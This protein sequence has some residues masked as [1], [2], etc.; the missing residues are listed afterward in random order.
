MHAYTFVIV[1]VQFND[2][3][4][5]PLCSDESDVEL[6]GLQAMLGSHVPVYGTPRSGYT[7]HDLISMVCE[8]VPGMKVCTQKPTGVRTFTSFVVDLKRV[9]LKD[10]AADDNGVWVTSTPR[11]M[12]EIERKE[13][14]ICSLRHISKVTSEIDKHNVITLCRQYGTHQATP[15]FRRII[16]TVIDSKGV[17]MPRAIVQYFFLGDKKVPVHVQPHGNSKAKERPYYRTQP[18][19]LQAIKER[20]K[21]NPASVTYSDIF[22]A[23]GGID[24]CKSMSEEPRN[25][26]QVYNAC[27]S[28]KNESLE[29]KD[30]IYDLLALLKEHQ[31]LEDGGFLREVLIGSTPCAILASKR[32]LDNVVMFCCQPTQFS[33]FGIDATFELGD[34]YVTLTTYKNPSLR[35]CRTNNLPVFLGPAFIHMERRTQDYQSFFSSLLKFEPR[36]RDLKAYGTDGEAALTAALESCFP[37]AI[38]LRC[39]IHKRNNIE[40]HLKG[41]SSAVKKEILRDI[42]GSQDGEVFNTGLVDSDSEEAFDVGLGRIYQRWEQLAPGLH[43]WFLTHQADVFCRHMIRPIREQ[44]Q[45]GSPPEKF[46]NNPNE[47]SNS[48]VKHWTGFKK[49]S[50]PAFVQKLQKLVESQLS[51]ADKAIYG[52]GE[53]SLPAELSHFQVDGVRWHRMSTAQRKAHLR[54]IASAISANQDKTHSKKLSVSATDV[55]L[56]TISTT[57]LQNMWGK[58]ERLLATP[59]AITPAPGN[60]SAR[61]VVSDSSPRPHFVQKTTSG[62]FL[63]DDSC[64]MWRGRKVCA[65]TV[66]VAESLNCLQ[67]FIEALQKSKPECSVTKLVTTSSDRRKAG[68]KSGAPRK[69]GSDL[70]KTPVTTYRSRLDDVCSPDLGTSSGTKTTPSTSCGGYGQHSS[71][72]AKNSS[73]SGDIS[74]GYTSQTFLSGCSPQY[75]GDYPNYFPMSPWYGSDFLQPSYPYCESQGMYGYPYGTQFQSPPQMFSSPQSE[76]S[77]AAATNPFIV[78]L[79][80]NRIKKCRG[81]NRE[82]SRK[83]DGSPPDP[84]LNLVICHEERRPFCGA[85]NATRLSRPQN[86][87]YH[88]N[89]AC[90]RANN[91]TFVGREVQI[92]TDIELSGAHKKYLRE[93]FGCE[94]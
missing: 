42:F 21:T 41:S 63:C 79:L 70:Y 35:N 90:V 32:Q 67:Q 89:L 78:K 34:F 51:E 1:C 26:S 16:A 29:S 68:T 92:P 76:S 12:Y 44:A 59:N 88:A 50:W 8:D 55:Q 60:K 13:G 93:H 6:K 33:V 19:T 94:C 62:K 14:V 5:F 77:F 54:E 11:R 57:T 40:E 4:F 64:P 15:E 17:T 45:L 28:V 56:T 73:I 46:T 27:K 39:F 24:S 61:M 22:E 81:C 20:C 37:N 83:V 43:K 82:F 25:K 53:Y 87:Y 80:N 23:A 49:N 10:L 58:A 85:S 84:P 2:V 47:S 91:P 3:L 72:A 36:L 31:S 86:V 48:V 66:A 18:S 75:R 65:H 9:N 7:A 69:R 74:V 71:I 52:A 38:S 30:E